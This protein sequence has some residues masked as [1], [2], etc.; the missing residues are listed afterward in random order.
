[1]STAILTSKENQA[2]GQLVYLHTATQQVG[3]RAAQ[4]LGSCW[5]ARGH[6]HTVLL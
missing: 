2:V 1:M 5:P 4:E 3:D 6:E